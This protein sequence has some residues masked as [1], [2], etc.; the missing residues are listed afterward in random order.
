MRALRVFKKVP[1]FGL[2]GK[3]GKEGWI[4]LHKEDIHNVTCIC[5]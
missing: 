5:D 4:K 3:D 1:I 2:K